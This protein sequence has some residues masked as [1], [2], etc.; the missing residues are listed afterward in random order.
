[1]NKIGLFYGPLGGNVEAVT[2][3]LV[4]KIGA[5][6][7]EL[8]PV[9]NA[10]KEKLESYD[11]IIFGISSLGKDA[12]ENDVK[13]DW[14]VFLP[15]VEAANLS[16]KTIA[17]F[18]LGNAVTYPSHF[19]ESLGHLGASLKANGI[20]LVGEM[21]NEGFE[22]QE[23]S[24]IKDNGNFYGLVLDHD[25][26]AEKSEARIEKWIPVIKTAFGF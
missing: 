19:V 9:K 22:Y 3:I 23:S 4:T 11:K 21:P 7:V 5:E 24:A 16:N 2:K 8:I 6:N 18:G 10:N 26:E 12:W 14:D 1:M 13:T 25:N 20:E 17:A 15:I